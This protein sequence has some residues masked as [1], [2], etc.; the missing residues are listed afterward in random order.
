[1]NARFLIVFYYMNREMYEDIKQ[2]NHIDIALLDM[3]Y[4]NREYKNR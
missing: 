4:H 2:C 3:Q 1:M